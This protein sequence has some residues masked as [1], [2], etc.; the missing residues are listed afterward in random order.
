MKAG[1]ARHGRNVEVRGWSQTSVPAIIYLSH[2]LFTV[3]LC[4]VQLFSSRQ[5]SEY[6]LVSASHLPIGALRHRCL[7][8]A[9]CPAIVWG[10]TIQ[11]GPHTGMTSTWIYWA[12]SQFW[13]C[14]PL[15]RK[16]ISH[17]THRTRLWTA[18]TSQASICYPTKVAS[19][20]CDNL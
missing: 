6:S 13:T 17:W 8:C 16:C 19:W 4:Y 2:G 11:T 14:F 9:P 10:L 18:T 12:I 5:A 1:I 15:M 3:S 20:G 7:F